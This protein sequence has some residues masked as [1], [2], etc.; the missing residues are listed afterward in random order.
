MPQFNNY[1]QTEAKFDT[2]FKQP[3]PGAYVVKIVAVRTAWEEY[4]FKTGLRD[5][6]STANDAAV[7][8]VYDIAEGEYEGEYSRDFYLDGNGVF[9]Q[10]KDFLHQYKFYWGDLNNQKDAEK[11]KYFLDCL[12]APNNPGFDALAAFQA[13]NWRLFIGQKFGV[14]LN[15]TVKTSDQGFENWNLK[16][17]RKIFTVGEIHNGKTVNAKGETVDLPKPKITDK[18]TNVDDGAAASTSASDGQDEQAPTS[19]YDD[20]IP[21]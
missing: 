18:R 8:F 2:G 13:D 19:V 6:C 3:M 5:S 7:V 1:N 15:G 4:N 17:Q 16:P 10:K 12:S 9:D 20:D 14:V 21:F 11:A